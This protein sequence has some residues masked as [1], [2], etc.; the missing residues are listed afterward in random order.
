M[1]TYKTAIMHY[2]SFTWQA[3]QSFLY[4]ICLEVASSRNALVDHIIY[5]CKEMDTTQELLLNYNAKF[6]NSTDS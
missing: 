1:Y 5:V 4:I 3:V 2:F 6:V